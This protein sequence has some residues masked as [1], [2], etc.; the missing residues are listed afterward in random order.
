VIFHLAAQVDVRKSINDPLL[1]ANVNLIGTINLL[2][3]A[4]A[5]GVEKFVFTSSG[6]CVYGEPDEAEPHD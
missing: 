4:R 3:A 1:D 5:T 2:E 6:G